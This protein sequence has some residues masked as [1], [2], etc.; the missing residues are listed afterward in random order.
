MKTSAIRHKISCSLLFFLGLFVCTSSNA[1][2]SDGYRHGD[3]YYRGGG[4]EHN[5]GYYRGGSYNHNGYHN[6]YYR[7]NGVVIGIPLVGSLAPACTTVRQCYRNGN[8]VLR[9]VCN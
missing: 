7:G 3:G 6:G 9:Q 5:N 2:Y 1:W 4:Y 8:C